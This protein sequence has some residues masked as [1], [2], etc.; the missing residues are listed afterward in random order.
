MATNSGRGKFN[1]RL[2]KMRRDRLQIKKDGKENDTEIVKNKVKASAIKSVVL[3]ITVVGGA[4]TNNLENDKTRVSENSNANI[5]KHVSTIP[6]DTPVK[7]NSTKEVKFH[8]NSERKVNDK[9]KRMVFTDK[10]NTADAVNVIDDNEL[11]I[12]RI[13]KLEKEILDA[14]KKRFIKNINELEILQSD[15]YIL[16]QIDANDVEYEKCE[17]NIKELRSLISKIRIL[18]EK[19][20]F[21]KDNYDFEYLLGIDDS[22]LVDKIIE[23]RDLCTPRELAELTEEY[24]LL[25]EYQYLYSRIDDLEE[26]S[27]AYG[28]YKEKKVQELRERDI[29]FEDFKDNLVNID[30]INRSYISFVGQQNEFLKDL[31]EKISNIGVEEQVEYHLKGFNQLMAN[32]FKY[33]GLLLLSPLKGLLP[34]IATE[35]LITRNTLKN[36]RRNL[37]FEETSRMVY[38]AID[39]DSSIKY[40]IANVEDVSNLV[41]STLSDIVKLKKEFTDKFSGYPDLP[42][43]RDT[44]RKLNKMENAIIGNQVK[45]GVTMDKLKKNKQINEKKMKRVKK[46]NDTAEVVTKSSEHNND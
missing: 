12:E 35:T 45:L 31:E 26:K 22:A 42:E 32:N 25:D 40:A 21:L 39:Y 7:T 2:K 17:E 6:V 16:S 46:L 30:K 24:K 9:D 18:K 3:P 29:K 38:T 11:L 5:E 13:Q 14:L 1:D 8:Q 27:I 19:Y 4:L 36:L 44:I 10:I 15:L 34:S 43:Y 33:M 41:N 28:E 20:D 23:L 37:H